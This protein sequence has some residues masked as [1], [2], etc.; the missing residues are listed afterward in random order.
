VTRAQQAGLR[1]ED[2][3]RPSRR[4]LARLYRLDAKVRSALKQAR[5]RKELGPDGKTRVA[6]LLEGGP[7]PSGEDRAPP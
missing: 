2:I 1:V 6:G 5:R 3:P 4:K 7:S